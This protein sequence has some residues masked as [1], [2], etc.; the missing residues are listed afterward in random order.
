M[1]NSCFSTGSKT[2]GLA[3]QCTASGPV[4]DAQ[5]P[6]DEVTAS[7]DRLRSSLESDCELELLEARRQIC[8]LE[9]EIA[10]NDALVSSANRET[11]TARKELRMME[12]RLVVVEKLTAMDLE[13]REK[14]MVEVERVRKELGELRKER[15]EIV[16]VLGEVKR[17]VGER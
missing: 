2:D 9:R 16:K 5:E 1:P 15:D 7:I 4:L 10:R 12:E 3:I 8:Q 11:V 14:E 13:G 17:L 6:K